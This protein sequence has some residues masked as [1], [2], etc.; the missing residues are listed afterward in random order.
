MN[1]VIKLAQIAKKNNVIFGIRPIHKM[2]STLLEENYPTKGIEIK[3]KSSNFGPMLGFIP[4]KQELSKLQKHIHQPE[5]KEKVKKFNQQVQEAIQ[6]GYATKTTLILTKKR[7]NELADNGYITKRCSY[8]N[9]LTLQSRTLTNDILT[10]E[11][12]ESSK[13][14]FTLYEKKP[15]QSLEPLEVLSNSH[16]TP[17]PLIADYDLL[18]I[19]PHISDYGVKDLTRTDFSNNKLTLEHLTKKNNIKQKRKGFY[20]QRS[21]RLSDIINNSLR[22]TEH[23]II[24]HGEDTLNPQTAPDDNYPAMFFL[25]RSMGDFGSTNG[26]NEGAFAIIEKKGSSRLS[27]ESRFYL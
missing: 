3:A 22:G 21:E 12:H 10:F 18:L 1:H 17:K 7:I 13:G 23:S 8:N 4:I 11:A 27:G 5:G 15:D 19:A 24:Q 26:N 20:T 6:F 16:T 14:D 2:L 9:K 25:P